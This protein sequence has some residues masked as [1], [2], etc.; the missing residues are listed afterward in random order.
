MKRYDRWTRKE[1]EVL[2]SNFGRMRTERIAEQ[3]ERT[4]SAVFNRAHKLG[5][6]AQLPD[7]HMTLTQ[8]VERSGYTGRQLRRAAKRAKIRLQRAMPVR[9]G[10]KAHTYSI[11]EEQLMQICE[12]L[13]PVVGL[14]AKGEL[15]KWGVNKASAC[16]ECG[17]KDDPHYALD[18][19]ENCYRRG[20][21]K[22]R[23]RRMAEKA[24]REGY[25]EGLERATGLASKWL[26]EKLTP[27]GRTVRGFTR[28]VV[29]EL[30]IQLEREIEDE[31]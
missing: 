3:L 2:R 6:R 29:K 28:D 5:L 22:R 30:V 8:A 17:T 11:T 7:G 19:C 9:P 26:G 20:Y 23:R 27:E 4:P 25:V 14:R 18:L 24:R 12:V 16:I 10:R 15:A 1:D 21:E 13:D 31:R